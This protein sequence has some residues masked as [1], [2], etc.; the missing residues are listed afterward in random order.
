MTVEFLDKNVWICIV[1]K[2]LPK[3]HK[4][5]FKLEE[6]GWICYELQGDPDFWIKT[7]FDGLKI[8]C[9]SAVAVFSYYLIGF[10]LLVFIILVSEMHIIKLGIRL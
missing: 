7:G 4:I 3:D 2:I 1:D 10:I 9:F 5:S 8:P 6:Q